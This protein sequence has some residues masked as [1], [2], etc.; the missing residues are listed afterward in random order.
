MVR[1]DLARKIPLAFAAAAFGAAALGCGASVSSAGHGSGSHGGVGSPPP[2]HGGGPS[3]GE[4]LAAEL[5]TAGAATG[6]EAGLKDC[7]SMCIAP[8]VCDRRTGLCKTEMVAPTGVSPSGRPKLDAV[9]PAEP[10]PTCGGLCL[11]GERCLLR[12]GKQDCV[13]IENAP[14]R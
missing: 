2:P 1:S 12:D 5:L 9:S 7:P 14:R 3:K 6:I 11:P 13:A 10:E 4:L 8:A